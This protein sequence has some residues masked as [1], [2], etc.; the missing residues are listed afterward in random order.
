MVEAALSI[1][2]FKGIAGFYSGYFA[3]IFREIPF[4]SI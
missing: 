3:L 1:F 4:S 2:K